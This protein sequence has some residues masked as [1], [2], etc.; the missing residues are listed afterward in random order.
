MKRLKRPQRMFKAVLGASALAFALAVAIP[1]PHD[2]STPSRYAQTCRACK[3]QN[4]VSTTTLSEPAV[5][6]QPVWIILRPSSPAETPP[7]TSVV[8]LPSSR[9][10]PVRA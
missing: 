8:H 5:H 7:S 2:H 4:S 1:H 9:A 6:I 10:P 3:I